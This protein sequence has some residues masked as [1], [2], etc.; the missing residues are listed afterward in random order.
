MD[1]FTRSKKVTRSP[2]K[3]KK[4][5]ESSGDREEDKSMELIKNIWEEVQAIRKG[6]E[7]FRK[8]LIEIKRENKEL[9]TEINVLQA[10]VEEL[11]KMKKRDGSF[12][13][14]K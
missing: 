1:P 14:R 5:S 3:T 12:G 9:K 7:E 13:E 8:E 11:E 6:N 10:R 2:P 4:Y